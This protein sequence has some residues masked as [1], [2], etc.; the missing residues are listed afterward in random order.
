MT[1]PAVHGPAQLHGPAR[2]YGP[3]ALPGPRGPL[4]A[5]VLDALLRAP[6]SA[7]PE[8]WPPVA[9]VGP[10]SEDLHLA[11]HLCYE[12]HYR[13]LRGVAT[14]WEWDPELLRLRARLEREFMDGLRTDAAGG[15]DV[16]SEL[17]ELLAEP[18]GGAG[19]S[20]R[21]A[22][23]GEWWQMRE[24]FVH[25]SV[26]HHKEADPHALVIPRLHGRAKASLVAVE[27]DEFGA[28]RAEDVHAQLFVDLLGGAGLEPGYLHYLD[29]VPAPAIA[30]V[31]MMSMFGLH[32]GLRGAL[33]GHFAAAETTTAPS[34][35]RM[36]QALERL[37]A[38]PACVH[39]Y[40][41]HVEADAVHE[42]VMRRDVIGGLLDDEPELAPDV[43]LGI[44]AT[45]LL[46]DRLAHHLDTAWDRNTTS[47]LRPLDE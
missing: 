35:R 14:A 39:F 26:Y 13:G 30:I 18:V 42:Q 4:S 9:G 28:G 6:G 43:V 7:H 15:D 37:R 27:Y 34:S 44:Q 20:R 21:L 3:A 33:V 45:G 17:D 16:T 38:D 12:L 40:S 25:R 22:E 24:Y 23:S 11:L 19:T 46:E 5:A 2:L 8:E 36:V 32:R 1:A 47:L 41:E 10:Y 31:N 29:D